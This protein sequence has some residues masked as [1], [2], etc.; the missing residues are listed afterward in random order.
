MADANKTLVTRADFT[1][2][3]NA[4]AG[5]AQL[6][7]DGQASDV[8]SFT[9]VRDITGLITPGRIA[10]GRLLMLRDGSDVDWIFANVVLPPEAE[11]QSWQLFSRPELAPFRPFYTTTH[12][13]RTNLGDVVRLAVNSSVAL[14]VQY[15]K[16]GTAINTVLSS[17]TRAGWPATL[18]GV[19]DGQP[20]VVVP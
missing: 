19:A 6:L 5:R 7:F 13:Y 17:R 12:T 8:A 1:S 2:N 3:V 15:A 14:F 20:V 4:A 9:G 11:G 10:S 16:S 18:P